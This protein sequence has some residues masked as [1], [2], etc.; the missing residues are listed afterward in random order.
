MLWLVLPVLLAAVA[1]PSSSRGAQIYATAC[2]SCHG[3]QQ[4]GGA[5]APSLHGVGMASLDFQ[6]TTGRMPAAAPWL[7]VE[8]RDERSG[9]ALPLADVRALEAYLAPVVQGG[10]ALPVVT[11]G[12]NL[13]HG[14]SLYELNCQACHAVGGNGGDLGGIDWAPSLHRASISV[15][16]DAIR[17][18]PDQMPRFGPHQLDQRDLNDVASFVMQMQNPPAAPPPFRSTGPVPE[19]AVGYLGVIALVAFVFTFWRVEQKKGA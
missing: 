5:D 18:G 11:A 4:W 16:A 2:S 10:P 9:Q 8:Q 15:V 7:E 6:L 14:R 1:P 19:G 3:A 17:A 12:G 13:E